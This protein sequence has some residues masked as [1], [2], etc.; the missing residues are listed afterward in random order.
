MGYPKLGNWNR[1]KRIDDDKYLVRNLLTDESF[2]LDAYT[3]WFAKKLTCKNPNKIDRRLSKDEVSSIIVELNDKMMLKENRFLSK[4]VFNLMFTV[5]EV[6]TTPLLRLVSFFVNNVLLV[7]WLPLL[8][9][10]VYIFINAGGPI[11][12]NN[13]FLGSVVG[14]VLGI[15]LHELGH[16]VACLSYG[17]QVFEL[18][19]MLNC[20]VPGAYTLMD[21]KRI[22]NRFQRIQVY[23]AGVEMNLLLT[24]VSLIFCTLFESTSGMFFWMALNNVVVS[25]LNLTF[26]NGFDGALI[27]SELLGV[28]NLFEKARRITKSKKA[29]KILLNKGVSGTCTVVCCYILEIF[30]MTL[31]VM[32]LVNIMGMVL[33]FL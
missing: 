29:K 11:N 7:C 32:I 18:G 28:E 26:V 21:E 2:V 17:G 24:S 5:W 23:A 33:W 14:M 30:K 27:I 9:F 15:V 13:I 16:M 12:N 31:P 4:S 3:V 1:F 6:R 19:L 22:K 8:I 25:L 20:I 10:S